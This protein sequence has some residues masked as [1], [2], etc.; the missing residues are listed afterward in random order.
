MTFN[1]CLID[2]FEED[3]ETTYPGLASSFDEQ[4]QFMYGPQ[5]TACTSVD[6]DLCGLLYC[7]TDP[8]DPECT[9]GRQSRALEGT[10]CGKRRWCIQGEC[11]VRRNVEVSDT[12]YE[13]HANEWGPCSIS[14][15][16]V[17]IKTRELTCR[18]VVYDKSGRLEEIRSPVR[19]SLCHPDLKPSKTTEC[20]VK[21]C[22]ADWSV[23]EWSDCSKTCGA[24][25]LTR[26]VTCDIPEDTELTYRCFGSKPEKTKVC[27]LAPCEETGECVPRKGPIC[28]AKNYQAYCRI[29][30]YE[31]ECCYT[32]EQQRDRL[33]SWRGKRTIS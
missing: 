32:C 3:L 4:C 12:I 10:P 6:R 9:A 7:Q 20:P 14:C 29:P 11:Q 18:E 13:W 24:G 28:K 15:G 26:T 31:D 23:G 19:K 5:A 22:S 1:A 17:G 21:D 8:N 16:G 25:T 27:E 30:G 33:A 2:P